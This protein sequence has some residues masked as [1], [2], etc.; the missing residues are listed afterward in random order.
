MSDGSALHRMGSSH[1]DDFANALERGELVL[2]YQPQVDLSTG[3]VVGAEAL[4]RWLHPVG[5][6]LPPD[7]FLPAVA[8]TPLMPRL[9]DWVVANASAIAAGWNGA[10]VAV[11]IAASDVVRAGLV[12]SVRETLARTGLP[13][14][15]LTLE[16]TEHALVHDLTRATR[17]LRLLV[18]DGVRVSLDDFGTGY[19]SLLYLKELPI[20]EI[21]IDRA[22]TSGV[23]K[24]QDDEAIVAGVIRLGH[25]IGLRVV[26]EGVETGEQ[27]ELLAH[28]G[29]DLVQGFWFG[30]PEP[31]FTAFTEP[32]V[33]VAMPRPR[34]RRAP[35]RPPES[36]AALSAQT[37]IRSMVAEGASLH[38]IA[39]VLNRQGIRT[40]YGSRWVAATV[41]R[42]VTELS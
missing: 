30:Y 25:A 18:D 27:A 33:P 17:N 26:A 38:T 2:H 40:T 28:F 32:P 29:C 22:F 39:A 11:N 1:S 23:G 24:N 3:V 42:A 36:I 34:R 20:H 31:T 7:E 37:V 16:I 5:G 35:R 14:D 41:A 4:L 15:R 8:H 9:T 10:A 13:A 19:S 12:S 21:K 6:L